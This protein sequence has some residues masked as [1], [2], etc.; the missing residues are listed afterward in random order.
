MVE[1]IPITVVAAMVAGMW[2][3]FQKADQPGWWAC[4]PIFNLVGL[5]KVGSEPMSAL[6]FMLIPLVN[7]VLIF[8][9]LLR[10]ARY[11]G[12]GLGF[13]LGLV[14]LPFIFFPILGFGNAEYKPAL[15]N[16]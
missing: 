9:L 5:L 4:F 16:P 11:F 8:G 1:L 7:V 6:W 3:V 12:K 10:V 15:P 2:R 13:G 14:F